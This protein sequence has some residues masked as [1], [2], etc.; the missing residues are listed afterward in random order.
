[1]TFTATV[2]DTGFSPSQTPT[3]TVTFTYTI[4]GSSTVHTLGTV[5]LSGTGSTTTASYTTSSLVVIPNNGAYDVTAT[6]NGNSVFAP[7]NGSSISQTVTPTGS[8]T[9]LTSSTA[10]A[11]SVFGQPV[12]FTAKVTLGSGGPAAGQVQ[13]TNQNTGAVMGTI[14][15]NSSGIATLTTATLPVGNNG[16]LATFLGTTNATGSFQALTQTVN[17]DNTTVALASS[18]V[19]ANTSVTFSV[20]VKAATP[21]AGIPTGSV[22]FIIDGAFAG[23]GSLSNGK[24]SL[25]LSSGLPAGKHVIEAVYLGDADFTSGT[26]TITITFVNGRG[27]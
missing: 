23:F 14:T 4:P 13:F 11:A 15:L 26:Q 7:G 8:T 24:T 16:I 12:T 9:T 20:T 19:T 10:G 18:T 1:V 21:G 5:N 2:K 3:G 17:Q 6:Y 27:T 22:E 25:T